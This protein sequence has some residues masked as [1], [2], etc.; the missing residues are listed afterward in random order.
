[1]T[2]E[3]TSQIQ[4]SDHAVRSYRN[5]HV[6][7]GDDYHRIFQV[8]P[9]P[10]LLWKLERRILDEIVSA[11]S[12]GRVRRHLDFACG[13]GRIIGHLRSQCDESVGLDVSESMLDVARRVAPTARFI[14]GDIT[15]EPILEGERFDLI[16]A[17][18]FFLNAEAPLRQ[19]VIGELAQR[20]TCDG[21]LV[22]NNHGNLSS[23]TNRVLRRIRPGRTDLACLSHEDVASLVDSAGLRIAHVYHLGVLPATEKTMPLPA[24]IMLPIEQLARRLT[25]LRA[26]ANDLIYVCA[27]A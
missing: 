17:F 14:R 1:M 4:T 11:R 26:L 27:R 5:S 12:G 9:Y 2:G 20:M 6:G 16:T 7:K 8:K 3:P 10:A 13:T 24:P 18:R 25:P 15:N 23:L 21:I 22:L 19:L